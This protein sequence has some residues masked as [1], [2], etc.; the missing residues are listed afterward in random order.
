MKTLRFLS[1]L[2]LGL[3]LTFAFADYTQ[4]QESTATVTAELLNVR[5]SP[6]LNAPIVAELPVNTQVT[7]LGR[8]AGATARWAL[9]RSGDITGWV[10]SRFLLLT[11]NY[12]SLPVVEG[13][14]VVASPAASS[15]TTTTTTTSSATGRDGTTREIANFRTGPELTFQIIR[16][17]PAD[18]S[19]Q[20]LGRNFSSAWLRVNVE[21]QEGWIFAALVRVPGGVASL[22]V[23]DGS[24]PV[25]TAPSSSSAQT[26]A[27]A[28]AA[29]GVTRENGVYNI[30]IGVSPGGNTARDGRLN[31]YSFLGPVFYCIN[32]LGYTDVG[33]YRGGGIVATNNEG[34]VVFFASEAEIEAAGRDAVIK[35]EGIYTLSRDAAGV[36][37]FSGPNVHGE[38]FAF[39]WRNCSPGPILNNN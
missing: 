24:T 30:N 4:A 31:P 6:S 15:S 25:T 12:S 29:A 32:E 33:T 34:R 38:P 14:N 37:T 10:D 8:E 26:S 13:E 22:P 21:G 20:V 36:F 2:V 1:A 19:L 11:V 3:V 9:I 23:V 27:P 16:Q 5:Q 7:V 18:T 17:L 39:N 35:T 28:A